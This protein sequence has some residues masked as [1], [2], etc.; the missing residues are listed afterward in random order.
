MRSLSTFPSV[1][2]VLDRMRHSFFGD[3][4][5]VGL[6]AE[7]VLSPQEAFWGTTVPLDV[8]LRRTCTGCGGRGETLAGVVRALR[9]RRGSGVD[10][11]SSS[12][13][14][15]PAFGRAHASGSA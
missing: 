3:A 2:S 9:G 1:S 7:I 14:C 10:R 11:T 13:A 12:C 4:P 8:P 5:V 6:N 15:R